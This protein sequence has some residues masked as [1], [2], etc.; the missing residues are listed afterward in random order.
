MFIS[1]SRCWNGFAVASKL[2]EKR[3]RSGATMP[4][5]LPTICIIEDDDSVRRAL[6]RLLRSVGYCVE[7]Y[8]TAEAFLNCLA[9][10]QPSCLIL[11]VHLPGLSGLEL[12]RCLRAQGRILP[13]LVITAYTE[14]NVR[15]E[16]FQAGAIAFLPKPFEESS[17]LQAVWGVVKGESQANSSRKD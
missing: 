1:V 10:T 2:M 16:A 17:L 7:A 8:A 6:Q 11:D 13:A 12:Q 3:S 15:E 4:D 14:E 5:T 9:Q